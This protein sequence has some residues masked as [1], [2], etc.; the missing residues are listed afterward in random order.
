M[1]TNSQTRGGHAGHPF[2][3]P[4]YKNNM[5]L[6][7]WNAVALQY[8]IELKE[9]TLRRGEVLWEN[10]NKKLCNRKQKPTGKPGANADC[11]LWFIAIEHHIQDEAAAAILGA[12]LLES[13][14]SCD[15]GESALLDIAPEDDFGIG[16]D[17]EDE[18]VVAMNTTDDNKNEAAVVV[19]VQ[20]HCLHS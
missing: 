6:E 11:V 5:G 4:N 20:S 9:L 13:G 12:D 8:Q 1:D 16:G 3:A 7:A 19:L 17:K 10:W 15:N 14:H 2:G 18:E